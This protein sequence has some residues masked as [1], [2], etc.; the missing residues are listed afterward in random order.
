MGSPLVRVGP[1]GFS[2]ALA[3]GLSSIYGTAVLTPPAAPVRGLSGGTHR[4]ASS[5]V[6]APVSGLP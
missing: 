2:G 5:A 1:D 3:P 4:P 6:T